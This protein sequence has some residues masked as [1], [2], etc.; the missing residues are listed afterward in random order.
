VKAYIRERRQQLKAQLAGYTGFTKDLQ[1]LNKEAYYYA[2]Q[3]NEYKAV[4]KDRKKA[5][6]KAMELIRS[7]PAFKDFMQR[8]SRLAGLFNLG[9]G[10]GGSTPTWKDCKPVHKLSN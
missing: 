3:L 2:Q 7:A 9:S 8:N 1:K 6:A 4:F 5:E 10:T